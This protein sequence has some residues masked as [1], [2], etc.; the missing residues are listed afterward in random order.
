MWRVNGQRKKII[1]AENTLH[2]GIKRNPIL[3]YSAA[4]LVSY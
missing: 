1:L 2:F 4:T 3:K